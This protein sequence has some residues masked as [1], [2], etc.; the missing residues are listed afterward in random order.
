MWPWNAAWCAVQEADAWGRSAGQSIKGEGRR[1]LQRQL[2]A[3][4]AGVVHW[5][6]W[7]SYACPCLFAEAACVGAALMSSAC[8]CV[9]QLL[10]GVSG[11]CS[12]RRACG[13]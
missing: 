7:W 1:Q 10:C 12:L 11:T 3:V 13:G 2:P 5:F 4:L 8:A 6:W 9:W